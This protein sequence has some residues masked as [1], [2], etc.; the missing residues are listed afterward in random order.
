MGDLHIEQ[1]LVELLPGV[2]NVVLARI[3][4]N[5]AR[6][7]GAGN[8]RRGLH[9]IVVGEHA[10]LVLRGAVLHACALNEQHRSHGNKNSPYHEHPRPAKVAHM[11]ADAL[12]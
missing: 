1:N 5:Q 8:S 12:F 7:L 10:Q 2:C 9:R 11:V 6:G 4:D 3:G